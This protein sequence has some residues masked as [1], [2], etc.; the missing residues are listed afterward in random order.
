M[1]SLSQVPTGSLAAK[2]PAQNAKG[3]S[4]EYGQMV[5]ASFEKSFIP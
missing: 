5:K 3:T 4:G 1:S 2:V